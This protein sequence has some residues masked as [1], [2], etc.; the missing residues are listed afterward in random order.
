MSEKSYTMVESQIVSLYGRIRNKSLNL[1]VVMNYAEIIRGFSRAILDGEYSPTDLGLLSILMLALDQYTYGNDGDVIMPDRMYDELHQ[2]YMRR[3]HDQIIY[4]DVFQTQWNTVEHH[5]PYMVGSVRKVYNFN[6][7]YSFIDE[8]CSFRNMPCQGIKWIVAPKFDGIS[9]CLEIQNHT[10]VQAIT[11]GTRS[12]GQDITLVVERAQNLPDILKKLD[13]G[14]LKVELCVPQSNFEYLKQRGYKNR[15]SAT[16]AIVNSPKNIELA[17]YI[18]AVPLVWVENNNGVL[19]IHYNPPTSRKMSGVSADD[20]IQ[21]MQ[22]LTVFLKDPQYE[23]E[24]RTDGVILWTSPSDGGKFDDIM[25]HSMAFKVNTAEAFTKIKRIYLTVGR[26][27][28]ATPM[29]E[30]EPCE[31]NETVV[32]DVSLGSMPIYRRL[33]LHQDEEVIIYSA[34]DVIPQMRLPEE[35]IYPKNSPII[36]VDEVCPHCGKPLQY[37]R[38]TN[39]DCPVKQSGRILNF[40]EKTNVTKDISEK[41][42]EDL[43][44]AGLIRNI[45]DLFKLSIEKISS[46][47]GYTEYSATKMIDELNKLRATPMNESTFLGSLG[48]P[49]VSIK[50]ASVILEYFTLD[51]LMQM[52][53]WNRSVMLN[54][55]RGIGPEISKCLEKFL[56]E[57]R[58][59]I[60]ELRNMLH[61]E[62][63]KSYIGTVVFSGFRDPKWEDKFDRIGFQT[64]DSVTNKTTVC[65]ASNYGTRNAKNALNKQIPIYLQTEIEK[66]YK[67]AVEYSKKMGF[68]D[69]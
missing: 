17:Q 47:D 44:N 63:D 27:G 32:T 24:Y 29:L 6:D 53:G 35:R 64:S 21:E 39:V 62:K 46:L 65:I 49:G 10:L 11:R 20:I 1:D 69:E 60:R 14:F 43:F 26:T 15:R 4:A 18:H 34:G 41:T 30:V 61:I 42:I 28:K 66:A 52:S 33:G 37:D 58:E 8:E 40:I 3:G 67:R 48:C 5:A 16:S 50:T 23:Y 2:M 31:V 12:E 38:C 56:D 51:E 55:I 19:D 7:I 57:H 59:E 54:S 13:T 9:A 25:E 36:Y 22:E 45:P 68:L